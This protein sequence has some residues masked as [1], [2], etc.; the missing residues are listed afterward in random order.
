MSLHNVCKTAAG[1]VFRPTIN[2]MAVLTPQTNGLRPVMAIP[3]I[4]VSPV[5]ST[6][7]NLMNSIKTLHIHEEMPIQ[8]IPAI[9]PIPGLNDIKEETPVSIDDTMQCIKRT[10]QPKKWKKVHKHGFL[11]RLTTKGGLKSLQRRREKGR[12]YLT[13]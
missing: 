11:K 9:A 4:S 1:H 3:R 8:R 5:C 13:N 7:F 2:R 12:H 10:W 6:P